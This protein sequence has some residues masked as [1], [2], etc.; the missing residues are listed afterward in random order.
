LATT[1]LL[2]AYA[3]SVGVALAFVIGAIYMKRKLG[4][5]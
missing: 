1:G 2:I 4:I 5:G 3:I